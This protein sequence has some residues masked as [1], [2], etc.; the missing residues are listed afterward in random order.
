MNFF[1]IPKSLKVISN[2][3]G[4]HIGSGGDAHMLVDR[5]HSGFMS[6]TMYLWLFDAIG[7]RRNIPD[8]TD[9]FKLAPGH[10]IGTNLKNAAALTGLVTVDIYAYRQYYYQYVVIDSASG[11][12]FHHT[13]HIGGNG[14]VN[15]YAP[16][17]WSSIHKYTNIWSGRM[18]QEGTTA[19]FSETADNYRFLRI[20][21]DNQVGQIEQIVTPNRQEITLGSQY[22]NADE[23]GGTLYQIKLFLIGGSVQIQ[24]NQA[25]DLAPANVG[26]H[27][28]N[29]IAILKIEGV[30]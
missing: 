5:E 19:K 4:S 15:E 13:I 1:N 30:I 7:Y 21:I 27:P 3:L 12:L 18:D 29:R 11:K 9:I 14:K 28:G 10:Y 26:P 25:V 2:R 8:Q 17:D 22:V 24:H 23:K 20:T 16:T 6:P